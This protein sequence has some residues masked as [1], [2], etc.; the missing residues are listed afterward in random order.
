MLIVWDFGTF[1]PEGDRVVYGLT[2]NI[3]TFNP[4]RI[5]GHEYAEM[6]RD[7]AR[8][9]TWRDRLS[10]VLRGPGWAGRRRA[11]QLADENREPLAQP[12]AA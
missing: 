5:A 8:S 1:E 11:E 7:V 9:R 6:L 2:K 4:M 10:F 12:R 3:K